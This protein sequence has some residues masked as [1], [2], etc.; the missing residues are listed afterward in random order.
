MKDLA[1]VGNRPYPSELLENVLKENLGE[2]TVM[3]EIKHPKIMVTAVMADRKPV[4]LHLFKNYKSASDILGIITPSTNRRIPPP[5]PGELIFI[6]KIFVAILIASIFFF[7]E[8]QLI[9]RAARATG[10]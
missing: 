5:T 9:W 6:M 3:S 4:D 8:N 10:E 7:T 1:F 2:Y